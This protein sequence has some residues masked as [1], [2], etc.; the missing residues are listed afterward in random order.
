VLA[1]GPRPA[2]DVRRRPVQPGPDLRHPAPVLL[3]R[4]LLALVRR[5]SDAV[6]H[7][8]LSRQTC[9]AVNPPS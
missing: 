4:R 8:R 6:L 9:R 2:P 1:A 7:R 5:R 3:G